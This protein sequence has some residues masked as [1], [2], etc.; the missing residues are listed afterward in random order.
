[1]NKI[2]ICYCEPYHF[3]FS[4]DEKACQ[5]FTI[6][7]SLFVEG[8]FDFFGLNH[9]TT[10]LTT[11]GNVG[12]SVPSF[13]EDVWAQRLFDPSWTATGDKNRKV[14][15]PILRDTVE[16]FPLLYFYRKDAQYETPK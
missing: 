15:E 2:S 8:T 11:A 12:N 16:T 10:S 5:H 1:M 13:E 7:S 6:I 9:Y 14:S 3:S 4:T